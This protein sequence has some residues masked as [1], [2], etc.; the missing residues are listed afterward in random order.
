M[1]VARPNQSAS[2]DANVLLLMVLAIPVLGIATFFALL[3]AWLVLPF[4]G[5]E[6]LALGTALYRVNRKLQYRH[7][8]TVDADSVCIDK[9]YHTALQHWQL[10]RQHSGLTI[11]TQAH[12]WDGPQLCVHDSNVC[13]T[14]GEFLNRDDSLKLQALLQQEIRVRAHSDAA[15]LEF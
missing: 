5:L 8:I 14:L 1:I 10:P 12:D 7:I 9:G 4:A 13:I 6:L 3:G 2:W 11:T 15:L